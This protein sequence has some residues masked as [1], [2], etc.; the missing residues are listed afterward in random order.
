MT[1]SLTIIPPNYALIYAKI[2]RHVAAADALLESDRVYRASEEV[3]EAM[4]AIKA[5]ETVSC[6]VTKM[7]TKEA[8]PND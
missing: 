7:V 6:M 4:E 8:L 5:F 1:E 3:S 2:A